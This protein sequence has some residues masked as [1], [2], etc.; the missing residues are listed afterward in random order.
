MSPRQN[1][2]AIQNCFICRPSDSTA[3][4]DAWTFATLALA[5]K[6]SNRSARSHPQYFALEYFF[7]KF[8]FNDGNTAQILYRKLENN[9]PWKETARS[10]VPIY[11]V[12]TFIYLWAIYTFP[13]SVCLFGC[14][15]IRGPI[16]G[17]YKSLSD[18]WTWKLGTRPRSLIFGNI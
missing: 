1:Q 2:D 11:T 10:P 17:I 7:S 12:H 6:R 8:V 9:I 3:S 15:K 5:A 13:R 14:S 16:L 4:E 18:V